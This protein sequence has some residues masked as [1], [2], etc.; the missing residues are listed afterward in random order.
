MY[1][2]AGAFL[3]RRP[4]PAGT[5]QQ[6]DA[7]FNILMAKAAGFLFIKANSIV[8]DADTNAV[9]RKPEVNAD[10]LCLGMLDNITNDF[11]YDTEDLKLCF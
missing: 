1:Q 5:F 10:A 8:L 3:W 6:L 11:L 4:E 7:K 9:F 2:E